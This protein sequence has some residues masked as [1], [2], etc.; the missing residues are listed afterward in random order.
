MKPRDI[1]LNR[2]RQ[3]EPKLDALRQEIIRDL[4]RHELPR[5]ALPPAPRLPWLSTKP[6]RFI[7][8]ATAWLIVILLHVD[9]VAPISASPGSAAAISPRQLTLNVRENRRQLFETLDVSFKA[10]DAPA[11]PTPRSALRTGLFNA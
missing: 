6:W 8:L 11:V 5:S 3:A 7:A 1:L 10:D 2:H 9:T 4:R